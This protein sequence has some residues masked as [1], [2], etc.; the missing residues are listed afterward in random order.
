MIYVD[1]SKTLE[2]K[3]TTGIQRVVKNFTREL[4]EKSGNRIVLLIYDKGLR[5]FRIVCTDGFMKFVEDS[6]KRDFDRLS[7]VTDDAIGV[8]EMGAGNIFLDIDGVWLASYGRSRL[9]PKLKK[10]GIKIAV[11]I[12]D[13]IPVIMPQYCHQNTVMHFLEY[14]GAVLQYADC[15]ITSTQ[16]TGIAIEKLED[17]LGTKHVPSFVSWLGSDFERHNVNEK[18][19]EKTGTNSGEETPD[20]APDVIDALCEGKYILCVGTIEPRKNHALLL[21]AFEE[22]LFDEGLS[23]VFVGRSG[24]NIEPFIRR[25]KGSRYMGSQLFWLEGI[26][27]DMLSWLYAHSFLTVSASFEEGFG[28][29]I[30][31]ALEYDAPILVSDIPVFREVGGD[32]CTYFDPHDEKNFIAKVHDAIQDRRNIAA[33][34]ERYHPVTWH[35][36]TEKLAAALES[37]APRERPIKTDVRQMVVLSARVKNMHDTMKYID[38]F[39]PFIEEVVICC[40]DDVAKDM[41]EGYHGRLDVKILTD[42]DVLAGRALP[43]DHATRNPFLRCLAMRNDVIDDVFIMSDDDYRPLETIDKSVFVDDCGYKGYYFYFIDEWLGSCGEYTSFDVAERKTADFLRQH[44]LPLRQYASHMPQIIDKDVYI[45][46][47]DKFPGIETMGLGEWDVYFNYLQAMYPQIF[48]ARETV[49]MC[50]PGAGTDWRVT[51]K[52]KKYLFENFYAELYRKGRIFSGFSTE[53]SE[54]CLTE[55]AKKIKLYDDEMCRYMAWQSVYDKYY[56]RYIEEQHDSPAIYVDYEKETPAVYGPTYMELPRGGFVRIKYVVMADENIYR[57]IK[58]EYAF[59]GSV[60]RQVNPIAWK[61]GNQIVVKDVHG[62]IPVHVPNHA[63]ENEI[64][65]RVTIRGVSTI[66]IIKAMIV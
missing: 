6:G 16:T 47:I 33:Q 13:I 36:A 18:A 20:I 45:E 34:R 41:R 35:E 49:S 64:A 44:G 4:V 5:K 8:S 3:Y 52:P 57:E 43:E 11:Y 10:Y 53:Y 1:I 21:D 38:A 48:E 29:P 56:E 55:N 58:I 46:M 59:G 28:L 62:E 26:S 12:Y 32:F 40:P 60:R 63:G 50:W 9:Y 2:V 27:D 25:M 39:M 7:I 22:R 23:L 14:I 31:E 15:I 51:I 17:E 61:G 30:I 54:A 65:V 37:L 66:A 19:K 42:D 24:W